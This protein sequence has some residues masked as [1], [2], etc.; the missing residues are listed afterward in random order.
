MRLGLAFAVL[1]LSIIA[2]FPVLAQKGKPA[3][4]TYS[5]SVKPILDKSCVSCHQ[6]EWA[7]G[8][9]KLDS[10]EGIKK[11]GSSGKVITAK[12]A[13]KSLL[14]QRM[15]GDKGKIMPPAGKLKE[16]DLKIIKAWID[17]GA[18]FK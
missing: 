15:N 17:S 13:A 14:F 11:G 7:Q 4:P 3:A 18:S 5:K 10:A 1:C 6:G 8:G 2:V 16:A 9:L 12:S